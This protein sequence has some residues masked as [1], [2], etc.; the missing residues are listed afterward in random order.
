MRTHGAWI[1]LMAV[2]AIEIAWLVFLA[3]LAFR[4]LH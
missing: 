3:V 1:R 2:S 4:P